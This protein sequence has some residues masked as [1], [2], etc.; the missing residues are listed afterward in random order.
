MFESTLHSSL[1]LGDAY[2]QAFVLNFLNLL[3][4][5]DIVNKRSL[6]MG[7]PAKA[8]LQRVAHSIDPRLRW[9]ATAAFTKAITEWDT[10][11]IHHSLTLWRIRNMECHTD[12]S[13][14]TLGSESEKNSHITISKLSTI[15][16][17][18]AFS[19]TISE[20]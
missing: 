20:C 6:W 17:T 3:F 15:S 5:S 11:L 2:T 1:T 9:P 4:E 16:I 13:N 19:S 10:S 14:S 18:P 8:Q 7:R 12:Q